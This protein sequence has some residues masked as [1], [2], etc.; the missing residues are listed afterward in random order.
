M[1]RATTK[2][3]WGSLRRGVLALC[4]VASLLAFTPVQAAP[5]LLVDGSGKLTGATGV[6]VQGSLYDVSFQDGTCESLFPNP[7]FP[8]CG[9]V[10]DFTFQSGASALA[11]SQALLDQ[12]FLDVGASLDTAFDMIPNLT[13]GCTGQS[14][15]ALTPYG[16][17]GIQFFVGAAENHGAFDGLPDVA[18]LSSRLFSLGDTSNDP[19]QVFAVWSLSPAVDVPE[20]ASLALLALGLAG[21]GWSR[22]KQV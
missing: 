19:A 7:A 21:L 1:K 5:I 18:L 22:R 14:C 16:L 20:P 17:G 3:V 4:A 10:S 2:V 8:G 6:V 11:A 13:R 12:V 9:D 15:V